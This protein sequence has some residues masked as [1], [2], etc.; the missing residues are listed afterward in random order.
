MAGR[1]GNKDYFRAR[2]GPGSRHKTLSRARAARWL[3]GPIGPCRALKGPHSHPIGSTVLHITRFMTRTSCCCHCD[4]APNT[5]NF[6][7]FRI[8]MLLS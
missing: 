5:I 8:Y 7:L 3:H 4:A 2:A 6:Y 1:V